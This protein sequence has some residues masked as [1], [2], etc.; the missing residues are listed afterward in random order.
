MTTPNDIKADVKSHEGRE[1]KAQKALRLI[2]ALDGDTKRQ[3]AKQFEQY[4]PAVRDALRRNVPRK[5]LLK[6]LEEGGLKLY[7]ALFDELIEAFAN[8]SNDGGESH[9]CPTC[10]HVPT[11]LTEKPQLASRPM[12]AALALPRHGSAAEITQENN[13]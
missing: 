9:G 3:K 5:A 1:T 11:P 10:G 7:P 2:A 4:Y 6:I 12:A 13:P 8:Q